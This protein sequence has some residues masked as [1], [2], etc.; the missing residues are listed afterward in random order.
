M[1]G[2]NPDPERL[3]E[4]IALAIKAAIAP[5]QRDIAVLQ[6]RAGLVVPSAGTMPPA[7]DADV[8]ASLAAHDERIKAIENRTTGVAWV[9][10]WQPGKTYAPQACVTHDGGLWICK[11][12]TS[13]EPGKDVNGWQLAVKRGRD[14]RDLR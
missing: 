12:A 5:L 7:A 1:P 8:A 3:G 14:G 13:G 6:T 2:R 11:A 4:I 10:V 9:G